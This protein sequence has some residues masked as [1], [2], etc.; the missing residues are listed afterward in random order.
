MQPTRA[1]LLAILPIVSTACRPD[2]DDSGKGSPETQAGSACMPVDDGATCPAPAAVDPSA[3]SGSCGSDVVSVTGTGTYEDN[4]NWWA[5]DTGELQPGCC[6]PVRETLPTCVYGRPLK[7]DG[8]ARL[9]EETAD[10]AWAA[11]LVPASVPPE[12]RAALARR[13]TRAAFDEH[14]SVA[15]FSK[16][17]LDLVRL[18]AP[19]ELV[20]RT[21][22]AAR[23]EVRH[24]ELG[25]AVASAMAG[26]PVGPGPYALDTVPLAPDLAT[27]AAETALEGCIGEGL[28]SLLARA[29]AERA[30]DPVLR[31]VLAT[32]A[33][34]EAGHALLAWRTLR[35]ALD[36]GGAPVREAVARVFQDAIDNGIA[37]PE[38]PEED[39]SAWGLLSRTEAE[40]LGRRCLA[41]VI[42]PAARAL[43]GGGPSTHLP[44][45]PPTAA[46]SA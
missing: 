12:V 11:A 39:L 38:A 34:E 44:A 27:F 23:E 19:P 31:D 8:E 40:A 9:A 32:I 35:W 17:V 2:D 24:A 36:L 43:L 15:A 13:W 41:E 7:V 22:Q 14:A 20:D 5:A 21:L 37:V 28:A 16:V 29:G 1:L 42:E 26:R 18:G 33:A 30:Q 45:P 10:S 3:L 46:A 4:I 25:F 6:Y